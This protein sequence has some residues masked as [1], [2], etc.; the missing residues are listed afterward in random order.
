MKDY[1]VIKFTVAFIIGILSHHFIK[2]NLPFLLI[3]I[4]INLGFFLL[5]N[6]IRLN[7]KIFVL[8]SIVVLMLILSIGNLSAHL[9]ESHFNPVV[10]K[11]YKEK[12]V[13]VLGRVKK[14]ELK[15][16]YEI[17]FVLDTDEFT[18]NNIHIN[19][20]MQF[21]CKFRAGDKE[22]EEFYN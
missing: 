16:E 18:I 12:N 8:R 14:I 10:E 4:L 17:L 6:Q 1:P 2:V 13:T 22:N 7:H 11:L 5:S 21:L 9:N 20:K 19:D 15:R 3:L